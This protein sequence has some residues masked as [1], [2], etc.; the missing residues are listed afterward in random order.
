MLEKL[1]SLRSRMR[2]STATSE[3]KLYMAS[4]WQLIWRKFRK[5]KMALVGMAIL[6]VLYMLAIFSEFFAPHDFAK[7]NRRSVLAPPSSIRFF[8][9]E[10]SLRWPFVYAVEMK[11]D[12]VTWRRGYVENTDEP[13]PLRFFVKGDPYLMLGLIPMET[14]FLGVE[15]DGV[16]YPFGT[17]GSGRDL[18]SR[19]FHAL[20]VSMTAGLVGVFFTFILGCTLGGISGYYGGFA[21]TVIQR[22]IEFL[23][24]IPSI[25]LWMALSACFPKDWTALETYFAITVI[26]SLI[27]WC[28]LARVV[29]GKFMELRQEDFVM[30]ARVSG[31]SDGY[32]IRKHLLPS[33]TSYLIVNVT[34]AIPTMILGESSLSFLGIGLRPPIVSLGVLLKDAQS[35]NSIS[36]SP[37]LLI[38]GIFIILSVLAF[39][40]VGDGLRDAADPYK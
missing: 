7:R 11:Q 18:C 23:M 32:I 27:G 37:W 12:P 29:R 20:R 25:P 33:F 15:K 8:D 10:G 16:F 3:E 5:H 21:D 26:L 6:F 36:I 38:P 24:S 34:L 2:S 39:N 22:I 31:A 19:I 9:K 13:H 35:I 40:F 4:Q 1:L 28:N 30:A 14:H 17:D